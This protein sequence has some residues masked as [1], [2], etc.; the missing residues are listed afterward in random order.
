MNKL[1]LLIALV[2]FSLTCRAQITGFIH[3][4]STNSFAM[5][6]GDSVVCA[7]YTYAYST[8][9]PGA[10]TYSWIL[11][12]GWYGLTGQGTSSISATCNV[13]SGNICVEGFDANANSV[14]IECIATQ[15]GNGGAQG[16]DVVPSSVAY[17]SG[18]GTSATFTIQPN[19]T[20][21]GNCPPGCGTGALHPNLIYGLYDNSFP[22][23]LFVEEIGNFTVLPGISSSYFV[24]YVDVTLGYDF[25][26]AVI[27][28][29]GCGAATINNVVSVNE[30]FPV[31]PVLVQSPDPACVGDTVLI[32]QTDATVDNLYW[33]AVSGVTILNNPSP[34]EA[35]IVIDSL[36][37]EIGYSGYDV[38]YGCFTWAIYPI[39]IIS[40]GPP[41]ASF[42]ATSNPICP[43]TCTGF[44]NLS[45]GATSYEW[46]FAG[47][48]P[49]SSTAANPANICYNTP[50]SYDVTLIAVN[51]AG[52]DTLSLSGYI[53]VLAY[54][55]PQSIVQIGDTL[56]SSQGFL[57][58]Q[59]YFNT[60]LI[61]GATDYYYVAMQNGDYNLI[62]ADSNGCE[63]EAAIF[64]VLTGLQ[65]SF[66]AHLFAFPNP[67]TET[68][69]ISGWAPR[70]GL[71]ISVFNVIGE[72]MTVP[73]STYGAEEIAIGVKGLLP[74]IYFVEMK[75]GH[76]AM[77]TR[78]VKQ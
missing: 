64:N 26:D 65:S 42:T 39:N 1:I 62:C 34:Q 54:P 58:Y 56:F 75:S 48:N 3:T 57:S 9:I 5:I 31:P 7:G 45:S 38:I 36:P 71:A 23:K 53:T 20:G 14:G 35:L 66:L 44:S 46:T 21:T 60:S 78:F 10:V 33:N 19:G 40:C 43:G 18:S 47:A 32:T 70:T 77:R 27:I 28:S 55:P 8:S 4:G 11:P 63:V 12:M 13:N 50:G 51:A 25:P 37:A 72:K 22:N 2:L 76:G 67:A 73:V 29:G 49:S 24:Y 69:I 59:W 17:C 74:G 52:S 41:L 15:W 61:S 30:V 68:I 6:A 16:W